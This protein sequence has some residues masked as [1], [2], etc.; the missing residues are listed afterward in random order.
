MRPMLRERNTFGRVEGT[1]ASRRSHHSRDV[2]SGRCD[3]DRGSRAD[4]RLVSPDEGDSGCT[5]DY[6]FG[7][8]DQTRWTCF[9]VP[10]RWCGSIPSASRRCVLTMWEAAEISFRSES[11]SRMAALHYSQL[12][13]RTMRLFASRSRAKCSM[14][15]MRCP[16]SGT[17]GCF[18]SSGRSRCPGDR[19]CRIGRRVAHHLWRW[20][21]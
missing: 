10:R 8:C 6:L 13:V 21:R 18:H 20:G 15:G 19:Q 7:T 16:V 2:D 17:L 5:R 11:S 4:N 9:R 14:P 12:A 3:P 1:R